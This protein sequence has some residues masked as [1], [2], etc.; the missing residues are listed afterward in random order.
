MDDDP[1]QGRRGT[2][3]KAIERHRRRTPAACPFQAEELHQA[4]NIRVTISQ[5]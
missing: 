3:P 2:P 4:R 1:P 5:A